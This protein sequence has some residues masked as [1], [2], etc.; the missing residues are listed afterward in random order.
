MRGYP[1]GDCNNQEKPPNSQPCVGAGYG[2]PGCREDDEEATRW[3]KGAGQGQEGAGSTGSSS[4]WRKLEGIRTDIVVKRPPTVNSVTPNPATAETPS[5]DLPMPPQKLVD[6][7]IP[8][9]AR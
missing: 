5:G 6:S 1:S 3:K 9:E 8:S 7:Q 4:G 2:Q